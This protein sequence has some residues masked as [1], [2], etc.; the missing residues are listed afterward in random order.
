MSEERK[1]WFRNMATKEKVEYIWDYYKVHIIT[2][3][4]VIYLLGAFTSSVLNRK[5]YVLNIAF[6]GKY[7]DFDRLNEFSKEVT[8]ELIGD[9]S[10]KKQASIDFYGLVKNPNGNFTLDPASTQKLMARMGAQDIDVIIL[11]KN[12]FD[13]LASQGAF[14]R[15]DEI[16]ELNLSGLNVAKVEEPSNEV[17]PGAYGIYVRWNNKYLKNLGYD[18]NDKIIAIMANGQHK[19]LAIKFVKWLLNI[20]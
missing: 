17:K 19:D 18:Y 7:M 5:E 15:L 14:L 12:N 3:I 9:P 16:K 11:D 4:L 13:I 10:G 8:K 2:G 1:N 20:K 6:V